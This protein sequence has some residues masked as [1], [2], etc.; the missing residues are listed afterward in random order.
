MIDNGSRVYRKRHHL[1]PKKQADAM[2]KDISSLAQLVCDAQEVINNLIDEVVTTIHDRD[3]T[4]GQSLGRH[5]DLHLE[6]RMAAECDR[7]EKEY[8]EKGQKIQ[9]YANEKS[10]MKHVHEN[11]D[12]QCDRF[13]KTASSFLR[14]MTFL[15]IALALDIGCVSATSSIRASSGNIVPFIISQIANG[16]VFAIGTVMVLK[17]VEEI[18][19]MARWLPD[20]ESY[21]INYFRYGFFR[22]NWE[23]VLVSTEAAA[24]RMARAHVAQDTVN[25]TITDL[26]MKLRD[27]ERDGWI[28]SDDAKNRYAEIM[29]LRSSFNNWC[30]EKLD[31]LVSLTCTSSDTLYRFAGLIR[32]DHDITETEKDLLKYIRAKDV[33]SGKEMITEMVGDN[34]SFV[35]NHSEDKDF[36]NREE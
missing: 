25:K 10:L 2:L 32:M 36:K 22:L 21:Y 16:V 1:I 31:K 17:H 8:A 5:S 4:F 14:K 35:A 7:L 20:S 30:D 28:D 12:K 19:N 6:S 15:V 24:I 3:I 13:R 11:D 18:K 27:L 9:C 29:Y 26:I 34:V 33:E 23:K